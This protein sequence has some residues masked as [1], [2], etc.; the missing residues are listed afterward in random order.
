M[1]TNIKVIFFIKNRSSINVFA[2]STAKFDQQV[3]KEGNKCKRRKEVRVKR[4][5][6]V[7]WKGKELMKELNKKL[8]T[9]YYQENKAVKM[10]LCNK[11]KRK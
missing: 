11:E 3:D 2:S 9:N 5:K 10:N 6:R 8:A 1:A 7:K 4:D